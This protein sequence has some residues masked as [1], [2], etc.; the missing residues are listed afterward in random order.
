MI[1]GEDP[2]LQTE[3]LFFRRWE[4]GDAEV[5]FRWARDPDVGPAAGWPPHRDAAESLAVIRH[6]FNEPECRA[7]CLKDGGMPVGTVELMLNGRSDLTARA[8]ECELGYWLAKPFWGR[9][10]MPEAVREILRRAFEDLCM[11]TVWCGYYEGNDKSKR[12]QEKC[13]FRH[14]GSGTVA[15]PL[16]GETR[17]RHVTSLSREEWL[18]G[19]AGTAT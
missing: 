15:V 4:D 17:T 2:M 13:G 11:A 12:V 7:I 1:K 10:L 9:G 16:M 6:V 18:R 19:R 8:D 5:L 14:R 3:R